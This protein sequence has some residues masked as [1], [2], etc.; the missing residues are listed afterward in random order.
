MTFGYTMLMCVKL[1]AAQLLNLGGGGAG[2]GR[3]RGGAIRGGGRG[4]GPASGGI[5]GV[6]ELNK[7]QIKKLNEIL[8]HAKFQVTHR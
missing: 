8:R 5:G 4:G 7:S 6:D 1:V 2:G 3:G